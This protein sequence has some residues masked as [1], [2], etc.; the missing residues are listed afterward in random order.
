MPSLQVRFK[1][2]VLELPLLAPL[3]VT[4]AGSGVDALHWSYAAS[5]ALHFVVATVIAV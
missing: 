3:H 5:V 2:Q 4:G 1:S